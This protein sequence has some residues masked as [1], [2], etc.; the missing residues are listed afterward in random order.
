MAHTAIFIIGE[1]MLLL[2]L[3]A[4]TSLLAMKYSGFKGVVYQVPK[5][6]F[7]GERR[8]NHDPYT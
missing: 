3:L 7:L 6:R 2:P 8:D 5:I 4:A 1:D